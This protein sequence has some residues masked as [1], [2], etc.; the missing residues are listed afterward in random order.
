MQTSFTRLIRILPVGILLGAVAILPAAEW[1]LPLPTDANYR[2]VT[3]LPDW[4]VVG[5]YDDAEASR[6]GLRTTT[7]RDV[8][9]Q[10]VLNGGAGLARDDRAQ[11]L[12]LELRG[13]PDRAVWVGFGADDVDPNGRLDGQECRLMIGLDRGRWGIRAQA[14]GPTTW[15][16]ASLPAGTGVCR[17]D[18][19][20]DPR[21][22]TI[23]TLIVTDAA[24]T[25]AAETLAAFDPEWHRLPPGAAIDWRLARV[26]LRG[27]QA[28]LLGLSLRHAQR[29]VLIVR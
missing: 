9:L 12:C 7:A 19:V 27:E 1:R 14:M 3:S 22:E 28:E 11:V 26:Q 15:M 6:L 18:L 13:G 5:V 24:G 20:V 2:P 4:D 21:D 17:L 10:C 25:R 29:S 8:L 23:R 16:P